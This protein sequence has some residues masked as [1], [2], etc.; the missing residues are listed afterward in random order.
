MN[1]KQYPLFNILLLMGIIIGI[2]LNILYHL[3]STQPE[4]YIFIISYGLLFSFSY[5][6][7][8]TL[9]LI[10]TCAIAATLITIATPWFY[11]ACK[12]LGFYASLPGVLLCAYIV[13]CFHCAYHQDNRLTYNYSTLFYAVWN[14][15]CLIIFATIF[16]ALVWLLLLL[17]SNIFL[18]VS[19]H[20][21]KDLI[22]KPTSIIFINSIT[23][24]I[25]LAIGRD[26]VKIV[27]TMR[28]ILL[29][30]S[31]FLLPLLAIIGLTFLVLA[32]F[33][34]IFKQQ[35]LTYSHYL[36]SNLILFCILFLNGV[37]QDG[38][39]VNTS[40]LSGT[41]EDGQAL[42]KY[43]K[44]IHLLVEFFI[45]SLPIFSLIMLN[46]LLHENNF[47]TSLL[48]LDYYSL[49]RFAFVLLLNLYTISYAVSIIFSRNQ[50]YFLL[51]K[52]NIILAVISYIVLTATHLPLL[53]TK[54][55]EKPQ[56]SAINSPTP[57]SQLNTML[58]NMKQQLKAS[59][60]QWQ[61]YSGESD[62]THWIIMGYN[63]Q[64]PLYACRGHFKNGIHPGSF[65]DNH[66][67]VTFAGKSYALD[68]FEVLTGDVKNIQWLPGVDSER[69]QVT[70]LLAGYEI[71]SSSSKQDIRSL[72]VCRTIDNNKIQI[73]KVVAWHC[74]IAENAKEIG[75]NFFQQLFAVK[76]IIKN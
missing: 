3:H 66:C 11:T 70:L 37:Y 58:D 69:S 51:A 47:L 5:N 21:I 17:A 45:V 65:S 40:S 6:Q 20:F 13:H 23:F 73:G 41:A 46:N 14:T 71:T 30:I 75:S 16:T 67:I 44:V 22:G 10:L 49:T 76:K 36:F 4:L 15:F 68:H 62:K 7:R 57:S 12:S 26:N 31:Y 28:N 63:N 2:L 27:Q 72:Y 25:G 1:T 9:R 42:K 43:P 50:N 33:T 60:L 29:Q 59:N 54:Q 35:N 55:C 32:F 39:T 53:K 38:K 64:V 24:S 61:I 34:Y 52:A 8:S 74:L 19:I 18:L 56:A 48:K